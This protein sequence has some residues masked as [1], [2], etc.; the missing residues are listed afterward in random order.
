MCSSHSCSSMGA[1][2]GAGMGA[3]VGANS[4]SSRCRMV[5]DWQEPDQAQWP[6]KF[7]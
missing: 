3:G 7:V 4:C 5:E 1:D 6:G 2:M